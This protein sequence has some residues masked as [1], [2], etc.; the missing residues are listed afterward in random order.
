MLN[1][2]GYNIGSYVDSA[3]IEEKKSTTSPLLFSGIL[4]IISCSIKQTSLDQ[5]PLCLWARQYLGICCDGQNKPVILS[6]FTSWP[7][8]FPL[9]L[10]SS[11]A[12]NCSGLRTCVECLGQ[13]ECGWCGDPSDTGRGVCIE[14]SYRGPLKPANARAGSTRDRERDRLR[15][16]DMVLDQTLCSADRGYNWAFIQCPGKRTAGPGHRSTCSAGCTHKADM[17][18]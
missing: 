16:R 1:E 2:N 10:F 4:G 13:A 15:D 5:W 3:N 11:P 12:Q 14:G 7:L 8:L 18:G 6:H 9:F 17:A